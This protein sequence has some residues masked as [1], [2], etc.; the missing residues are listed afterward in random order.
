MSNFVLFGKIKF[1]MQPQAF[2]KEAIM[3]TR[4][5]IIVSVIGA[6]FYDIDFCTL[7][8]F[9]SVAILL[10]AELNNNTND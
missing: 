4:I 2:K 6:Y 5:G 10:Y 7:Y 8:T 9:V 1:Q 3:K